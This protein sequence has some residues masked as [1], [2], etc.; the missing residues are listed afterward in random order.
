MI[1]VVACFG[2]GTSELFHYRVYFLAVKF[3]YLIG[4]FARQKNESQIEVSSLS[5]ARLTLLGT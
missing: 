5:E 1:S 4:Y 3:T 2:L